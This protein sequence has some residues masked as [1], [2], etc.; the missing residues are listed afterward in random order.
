[1]RSSTLID[2]RS[3]PD[4]ARR[5]GLGWLGVLVGILL[6]AFA[7]RA[8]GLLS[9]SLWID[10]GYSLAL[11]QTRALEIVRGTAADQHPPLYYL[12]L[13][14]WLRL[15]RPQLALQAIFLVRYLSV[16]IGTLGV[17]AGAWCGRELLGKE[18]G[19][20]TALLLAVSPM[21]VWYS[22]EARMYI[23]LAL[24]VTLSAGMVWRLVH[25]R[26]G[27]AVY[28][29]VTVLALYTHYFAAFVIVAENV[30][31][32]AWLVW[33]RVARQPVGTSRLGWPFYRRWLGVQAAL[34]LCFSPWLPVAV[35][36]TRYHQMRWLAPPRALQIA[37]TPLLMVLGDAGRGPVGVLAFVGLG[38][39][40]VW[41]ICRE[42]QAADRRI[43]VTGYAF[44]LGWVLV[45]FGLVALLS[46]VFPLFQYKQM[47]MLL[48]PLLAVI[49]AALIRLPRPAQVALA[50]ALAWFVV[51]SLSGM[52]RVETKDG[53]REAGAYIE[54]RFRPGDV[55]YLNPAA[56]RLGL[57]V[58]LVEPLPHEGYPPEYDVR[59]GGWEGEPVTAAV[60]E[61]E[62]AALAGSYRRVW[63]VE[64][65]PEFWDPDGHL[66]AWLQDHGR[67]GS[68]E[69]F[70]RI[71]V[72]LYELDQERFP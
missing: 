51:G 5:A 40:V 58:Y 68:Q 54:A 49:A 36:Q 37:G 20:A 59:T 3:V 50:G 32:L 64:F 25:G 10:E 34:G 45:P 69:S 61:R 9:E 1:M 26:R 70:G 55:L 60:A 38:L 41:A 35:Y 66:R 39:A 13:G 52:V 7:L 56:G 48:T 31:V 71:V 23:L 46:L 19:L 28:G 21:H 17:A 44:A 11:A 65:G 14:A 62:M 43:Q 53:W 2:S 29:L 24:L 12:L 6:L 22:Q 18:A 67:P 72:T 8:G 15:G 16:L 57:D 30:L 27:W 63:L 4:A 47:L 33:V 42:R